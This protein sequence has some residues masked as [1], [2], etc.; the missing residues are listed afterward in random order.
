M[1]D[2]HIKTLMLR[3]AV[4]ATVIE[5]GAVLLD[6]DTK[7]FYSVNHGGWAI[8]QLF[9]A[10]TTREQVEAECRKWGARADDGDSIAK[11][12]DV[13]IGDKLVTTT[14]YVSAELD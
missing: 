1:S 7:Y 3:P 9:E 5:D 8:L 14:D 10:G 4:V 12:L 2:S 6:L 11:F 13:V